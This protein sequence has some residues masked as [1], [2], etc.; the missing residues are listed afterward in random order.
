[1]LASIVALTPL[2]DGSMKIPA[3][4][5]A[6]ELRAHLG[7][8]LSATIVGVSF[9][10][11]G[12]L[13]PG[14]PPLLLT[15]VRFAIAAA[16]LWPWVRHLRGGWPHRR[17]LP[18]YG[19]LGA[20]SAMFFAGMFWAAPQSTAVT[21]S[22]LFV[23][24]PLLAYGFGRLLRVEPRS[25]WMARTLL[26]GAVGALALI[27]AQGRGSVGRLQL[28]I[29]E[30]V[31]LLGCASL[32]LAPAVT[33]WG[34]ANDLLPA[35]SLLRTFWI[36]VFAGILVGIAGVASE[37]PTNLSRLGYRDAVLL[38]YLGV[39]SSGLTFGLTEYA[40]AILTPSAVKAYSYLAPFTAMLV[41][42]VSTPSR[43]SWHW[44]PGVVLVLLTMILLLR[45]D[46]TRRPAAVP[47]PRATNALNTCHSH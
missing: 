9:P 25:P 40:T 4:F 41:L 30:A 36:V 3:V 11:V 13:Q 29:P 44:L 31:F 1:M 34:L 47:V 6:H 39:F 15:A 12:M 37:S 38:L 27:W 28:G 45:R 23:C 10:V 33:K 46:L 35:N 18:L 7:L 19:L 32:A 20:C 8:L 22:T 21:L 16:V 42:F 14:L 24:L 2:L 17:H 43:M 5:A 26:L